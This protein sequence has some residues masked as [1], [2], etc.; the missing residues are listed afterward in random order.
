[1]RESTKKAG[2]WWA[3]SLVLTAELAC[4]GG[5]SPARATDGGDDS[6][7][8]DAAADTTSSLDGDVDQAARGDTVDDVITAD[9]TTMADSAIADGASETVATPAPDFIWYVLDETTGTTAKDSSS[10][11]YDVTNLTGTTW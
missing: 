5:K 9:D 10:H 3:L 8:S 2:R 1:M 7:T 11:H 6:T 4:N